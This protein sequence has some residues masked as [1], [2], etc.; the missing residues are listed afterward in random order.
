MPGLVFHRCS[1]NGRI[2]QNL[3]GC[4]DQGILALP[5][6]PSLCKTEKEKNEKLNHNLPHSPGNAQGQAVDGEGGGNI[7]HDTT[8]VVI[9]KDKWTQQAESFCSE[10]YLFCFQWYPFENLRL[11]GNGLKKEP[12]GILPTQ[13]LYIK[14]T[15]LLVSKSNEDTIRHDPWPIAIN[16]QGNSSLPEK[17]VTQYR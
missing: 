1:S 3:Q 17:L 11:K 16:L 14:E 5:C 2:C 13:D 6:L 9:C 4:D 7:Y 15:L 12:V 10:G 8:S